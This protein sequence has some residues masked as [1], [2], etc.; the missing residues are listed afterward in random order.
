M[1]LFS[2][3]SK[4]TSEPAHDGV[5]AEPAPDATADAELASGATPAVDENTDAAASVPITMSSFQGLGAQRAPQP[6]T[7]PPA[8]PALQRRRS[9]PELPPP[10]SESVPGLRDNV[11]VRQALTEL[12]DG[13]PTQELLNVARQMLQGH[14][15][16]RV[17][18]DAGALLSEGK[19]L[20]LA[21]VTVGDRRFALAYSNGRAL[22]ASVRADGDTDT[23]AM[24]QPVL[25]ILRHV[26][27]GGFDGLILDHSSAPSRAVLPTELLQ[28]IV[29]RADDQLTIKTLLAGE[30]TPATGAAIVAAL[31]DV[32]VWVAVSQ[33]EG[34]R[35]GIAEQR[36]ADG[37]RHLQVFSHP[38]EVAIM[39]RGDQAAPLT[40]A[41]IAA[42]LNSDQ[43]L[44][45]IVVDPA[46]PWIR[47]SREDLAPLLAPPL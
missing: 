45:G 4:K 25:S 39:G 34:G 36:S 12:A 17:K 22:G 32:P 13:A 3:R 11:L 38:L 23:S 21:M 31:A 24:G 28:K 37:A 8:E 19:Q 1:A 30:R 18:G 26:L 7:P 46:G 20:P 44:S 5:A 35:L 43:G 2:R 16:L 41:Q 9:A 33:A 47:L 15:Y 14:L 6:P 42:A 40:A 10:P 29:D 27:A